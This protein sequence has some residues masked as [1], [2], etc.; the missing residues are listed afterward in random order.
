MAK[1]SAH[2]SETPATQSLRRAGV[3][4]SEHVY[5]YVDRGGT[6]ESARQLGVDEHAV[7][8]TL[9]MQNEKAEPLIVLMHGDK[10]VSTKNLARAIGAKSV[11]PCTPEAAERA[12]RLPGRRHVA[13]RD[14]QGDA[15]VR[16]GDDP[17][18]RSHLHQRRPARLPD[19]HRAAAS[20]V[21]QLRRDAGVVR[22]VSRR[23]IH[24]QPRA[25]MTLAPLLPVARRARRL[26]GR[27]ALVRGH[28]QPGDGP[29]RPAHLRLGQ[30]GRDQRAALGQ[31]GGGD[32]DARARRAEGLVPVALAVHFGPADGLGEWTVALVAL[33]AFLGHLWPVFF[34]FQG[35]KGVAT[36]AGA[37]LGIDPLLGAATIA[38]WLIIAAFFRYSSLASIVAAVFAPFWQLLTRAPTRSRRPSP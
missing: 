7:V 23:R 15:G 10:Q 14:A 24:L 26:S 28:R 34:R 1:K 5:D 2:V 4:F 30:S 19:R 37:L 9:V 21:E 6:T 20:L 38:T 36:A 8:K 13:V 31:Q 25:A 18:A 11:A 17:R 16:R 29:E 35:G 22:A 27:L 12:Q 33:A 32:P 3:D